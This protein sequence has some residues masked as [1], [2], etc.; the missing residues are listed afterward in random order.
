MSVLGSLPGE[1]QVGKMSLAA[2]HP[3]G[4][5]ARILAAMH[6]LQ[7]WSLSLGRW[8]G[9]QLR[10]H[11]LFLVAAVTALHVSARYSDAI[12]TWYVG[13]GLWILLLSTLLHEMGRMTMAHQ[14]DGQASEI[15]LWPLGGLAFPQVPDEPRCVLAVAA[16]GPMVN[17]GICV[18]V[19]PVIL[20]GGGE[21]S[22]LFH[23]L[24]PPLPDA[25]RLSWVHTA[26]LLFWINWILVLVNAL[27]ASP[28]DAGRLLHV[29]ANRRLG[30]RRGA[31]WALRS[32]R[33]CAFGLWITAALTRQ[34]HSIAFL[35][36]V[37]LGTFLYF[38]AR[39]EWQRPRRRELDE[40]PA[41]TTAGD[42]PRLSQSASEGKPAHKGPLA[43]WL[44]ARKAAREARRAEIEAEEERRVDDILARLHEVG[45]QGLTPEERALLDRVSLRYRNRQQR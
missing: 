11:V 32:A 2:V 23:P 18:V 42:V 39:T 4:G 28:L 34:S 8:A 44:A 16:A 3:K 20:L 22:G 27:P 21:L 43:Q 10:V 38:S 9:V 12:M 15:V 33:A 24:R 5:V 14:V 25:E 13:T 17:A 19:A 7:S 35:P 31:E 40:E 26:S 30:R 6:D 45:I 36:L 41:Y 1:R 37:L 29:L